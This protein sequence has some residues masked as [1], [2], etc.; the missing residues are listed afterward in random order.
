MMKD[1]TILNEGIF[2]NKVGI[3][4]TFVS[5]SAIC[6]HEYAKKKKAHPIAHT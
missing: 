4:T 1:N 2:V 5:W 6:V 3:P